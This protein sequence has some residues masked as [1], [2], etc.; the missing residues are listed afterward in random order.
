LKLV[1]RK[2]LS[3]GRNDYK[4]VI[5][6]TCFRLLFSPELVDIIKNSFIR[7]KLRHEI[8]T[9]AAGLDSN[10]NTIFSK[11][12]MTHEQSFIDVSKYG[13]Q[14]EIC[15]NLACMSYNVSEIYI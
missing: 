9:N 1:A 11:I 12:P 4:S 3:R 2:K 8:S 14:Y 10:F 6:I 15:K 13:L 7:N 5:V